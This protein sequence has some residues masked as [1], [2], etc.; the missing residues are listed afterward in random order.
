MKD[1]VLQTEIISHLEHIA[2]AMRAYSDKSVVLDVFIETRETVPQNGTD[3]MAV[4]LSW[5][6]EDEDSTIFD[7]GIRIS[8]VWG[9]Y[10]DEMIRDTV[11][12]FGGKED[13]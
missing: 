13:E 4:K 6:T 3:F 10:G 12:C 8:Y 5:N 9:E 2:K 1:K 11:T 7:K